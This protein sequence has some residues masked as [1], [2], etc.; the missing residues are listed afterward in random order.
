MKK[1]NLNEATLGAVSGGNEGY[2]NDWTQKDVDDLKKACKSANVIMNEPF[3]NGVTEIWT[4]KDFY[5][6]DFAKSYRL[7][8]P[9]NK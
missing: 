3:R 2:G 9:G 6:S 1:A 5:D 8:K 7:K 4:V